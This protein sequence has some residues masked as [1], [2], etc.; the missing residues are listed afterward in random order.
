MEVRKYIEEKQEKLKPKD[1]KKYTNNIRE[2]YF[3][4]ITIDRGPIKY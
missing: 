3:T 4:I 1:F 2:R